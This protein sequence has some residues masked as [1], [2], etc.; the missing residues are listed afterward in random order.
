MRK[1]LLFFLVAVCCHQFSANAQSTCA[2]TLR[3]AQSVYEQ[4]RLQ[5]LP[6]LL[7]GCLNNGFTDQEK[8]NAYKLLTLTYI[9]LEEPAKADENMLALLRV[10]NEFKPNDAVDPAEF[11]AIYN[12]FRTWPIYR[13]GLKAGT[14]ISQP[15]V[16]SA[17]YVNSGST[18]YKYAFGFTLAIASE[19]QLKGLLRKFTLNPELSFQSRHFTS[20]NGNDDTV[21][22]TSS[23]EIQTWLSLPISL[24]YPV[25]SKRESFKIFAAAG[26]APE[27]L[28][29]AK[30]TLLSERTGFS[31]VEERDMNLAQSRNKFNIGLVASAGMK[32]KISKGYLV[33]ELRYQYNLLPALKSEDVFSQMS[34]IIDY[35]TVDG[36][37]RLSTLSLSVGYLL[38]RYNPKK[39]TR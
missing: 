28:V 27:Y 32:S 35:K 7:E 4:G 33:V 36:V 38:N 39:L 8:V 19:I 30:K 15:S 10:N 17:D 31:P 13:I 3:L 9:Y 18:N 23:T 24:Q 37:Y 6:N 25:F 16:I 2:Q 22:T 14:I 5:E 29:N 26:V 21:R 20:K 11:V 34:S 1:R 12:T